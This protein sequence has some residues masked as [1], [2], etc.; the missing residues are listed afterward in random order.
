MAIFTVPVVLNDFFRRV[1]GVTSSVVINRFINSSTLTTI[2]TYTTLAGIFVYMTLNTNMNTNMLMDHC[3]KTESCNG[4]G[5]VISASL[6]DF[7][8]LDVLLKVFNFYFSRSVVDLLRAPPSVLSR[9]IL[10]LQI[11]FIKFPFLFVCGVL[12]AVFASVNRSEVPLILLV[13]SSML[14]VFVSL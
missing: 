3:F 2:N 4:V 9:T 10:C 1:C 6:V 12:S 13:F 5:A 8:I 11:C 14:G 7:L